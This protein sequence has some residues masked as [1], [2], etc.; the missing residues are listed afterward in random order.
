MHY[1]KG[2]QGL[3]LPAFHKGCSRL[4]FQIAFNNFTK[5]LT[6]KKVP[7]AFHSLPSFDDVAVYPRM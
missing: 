2:Y 7:S 4:F 1:I 6:N 5:S 3:I